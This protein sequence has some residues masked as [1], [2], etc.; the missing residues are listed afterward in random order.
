MECKS[1]DPSEGKED[2]IGITDF[3]YKLEALRR[4]FG[5]TPRAFFASTS[6]NL[7]DEKE[8]VKFNFTDRAK[9]F[10]IEIIPLLKTSDLGGILSKTFFQA[11]FK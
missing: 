3:L 6:G 11:G 8:K 7:Y 4:H 10:S 2:K 1:L 5:L 9:Q